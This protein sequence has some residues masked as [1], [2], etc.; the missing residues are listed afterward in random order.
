MFGWIEG[1]MIILTDYSNLTCLPLPYRFP[2]SE[3]RYNPCIRPIR[4]LF[5]FRNSF[6]RVIK[7]TKLPREIIYGSERLQV[8]ITLR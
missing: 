7:L 3:N 8:R 4:Q 5:N 1:W 2:I 6:P